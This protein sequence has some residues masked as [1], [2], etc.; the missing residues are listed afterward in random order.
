MQIRSRSEFKTK[1]QFLPH[2]IHNTTGLQKIL[3]CTKH[4]IYSKCRCIFKF[5]LYC[6]SPQTSNQCQAL[7]PLRKIYADIFPKNC[8]VASLQIV[9]KYPQSE[10]YSFWSSGGVKEKH[11][12]TFSNP[13]ESS[14][15]PSD[16]Q[17]LRGMEMFWYTGS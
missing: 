7:A 1:H 17:L 4:A 3:K 12:L 15:P 10:N 5:A 13:T 2:T 14:M 9:L 16:N 8:L 11:Q 6:P